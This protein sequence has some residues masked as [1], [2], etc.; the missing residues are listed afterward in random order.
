VI[1]RVVTDDALTIAIAGAIA[2]AGKA[3]IRL[4]TARE[5]SRC[6]RSSWQSLRP[7]KKMGINMKSFL[8]CLLC[9]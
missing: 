5:D 3:R 8:D 4:P 1:V 6:W 9:A 2:D 7:I